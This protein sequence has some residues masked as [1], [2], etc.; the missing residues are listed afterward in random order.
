MPGQKSEETRLNHIKILVIQAKTIIIP[1]AY[2]YYSLIIRFNHHYFNLNNASL[3]KRPERFTII[4]AFD[5]PYF[6]LINGL[7]R[8]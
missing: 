2:F 1:R 6:I 3:C 5:D 7:S 8:A 4:K